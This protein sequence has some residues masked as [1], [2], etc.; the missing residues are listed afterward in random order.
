MSLM[1]LTFKN[2]ARLAI[3]SLRDTFSKID[4]PA[5]GRLSLFCI[6]SV[7][8]TETSLSRALLVY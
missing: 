8:Q 4:T 7:H 3:V 6:H 5:N 1:S 2:D